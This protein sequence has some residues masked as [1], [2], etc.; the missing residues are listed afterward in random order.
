MSTKRIL[1]LIDQAVEARKHS[2]EELSELAEILERK[3]YRVR[4]MANAAKALG[5]KRGGAQGSAI[6][7]RLLH[8]SSTEPMR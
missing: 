2:G 7:G 6:G 4:C 1:S 8:K 3:A 5:G